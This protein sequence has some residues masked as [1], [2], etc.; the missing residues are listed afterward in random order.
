MAVDAGKIIG[1]ATMGPDNPG[2][3]SH[4]STAPFLLDPRFQDLGTGRA[5]GKHFI[6]W[7]RREGYRGI[8][9]NAVAEDNHAAVHLWQS[10][11]CRITASVP[12]VFDHRE[13]GFVGRHVMFLHLA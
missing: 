4:I 10:L 6:G 2:R 3:G 9:F 7:A 12:G 13:H 11:G 8:Q 1:S 5:P